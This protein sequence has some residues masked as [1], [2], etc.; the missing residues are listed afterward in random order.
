M[1]S[2]ILCVG[3]ELVLGEILNTNSAWLAVRLA[4]IGIETIRHETVG[5]DEPKLIDS[6]LHSASDVDVVIVTG[7]IGPTPDDITRQALAKA[8]GVGLVRDQGALL[9]IEHLFAGWGR[10]MSASNAIQADFPEGSVIIPNPRG[11]AAGFRMPLG[12]AEVF[13]LPGVPSEMK[14]MWD[15]TVRNLLLGRGNGGAVVTRTVNCFGRGEADVTDQI[16]DLMAPGRN[17]SVGD[18]AED[19]VIK[20]RI[21]ATGDTR[22]AAMKLIEATKADVR[23]R[24]GDCVFGEDDDTLHSTVL[25]MLIERGATLATA[26]SCTGGLI[27]KLLTDISGS[28]AAFIQGVVAYHNEAKVRLLGV[29]RELIEKHGAVSEPVA[30]AMGEGARSS[31]GT[32]YAISITGIAGPTGGT[33]EKPVGLVYIAVASARGTES[34]EIRLR[35][36]RDQV[37][38]RSAK[39]ALNLLRTILISS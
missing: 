14:A 16:K 37:R 31:A 28:S 27:A 11:T 6:L 21:R 25:R 23:R 39:Q 7:G 2:A 34:R 15:E 8:A 38:D 12:R 13:V 4:E 24:L 17:P 1:K 32:D 30:R 29:P 5:D 18:T 19:A 20:V 10:K 9:H 35:G 36:T 26:E 33:S 3:S 22:D